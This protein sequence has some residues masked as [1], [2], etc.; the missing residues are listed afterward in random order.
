[1]SP[2]ECRQST[3]ELR[4]VD[5]Q[6]RTVDIVASTFDIDSYG[7]RIDQNG[8]DLAR[9]L[10]NPVICL[11]HDDHGYTGSN[12]LPVA[13][14]IPET[15]RVENNKLV[16]RI[17]FPAEGTFDVADTVFSLVSQG[18]L[19]GVSVGFDP[20][21]DEVVEE[22]DGGYKQS[23]RIY[24]KQELLE[25]SLVTIPS[26][27]KTLVQRARKQKVDAN[28][29]RT[30]TEHMEEVLDKQKV[31]IDPAEHDK[32]KAYFEQKQPANR[33]AT[34]VLAKFFKRV[35]KEEPPA[36]EVEAWKRFAEEV[37][38]MEVKPVEVVVD[39]EKVEEE[40]PAEVVESAP[41]EVKVDE[42]KEE[43]QPEAAVEEPEPAKP[44][45][46]EPEAPAPERKASV[47][48]PISDLLSLQA[49]LTSSYSEAAMEALS[50]GIPA[51]DVLG[52][53]DG[54]NSA[55]STSLSQ[56]PNGNS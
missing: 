36:D 6:A 11:Q 20:H 1:M 29:I 23:V 42:V 22:S 54:M 33:E 40:K 45:V 32:L 47:H 18:F 44:T 34:K 27:D 24:R 8:W 28:V 41:E 46:S 25:V 53:I 2:K 21:E 52:M 7:T 19:R 17:R 13:N 39:E 56:L 37:E 12:G 43:V 16:M 50:R 55:V 35:L 4:A 14:A 10:A 30:M 38:V 48:I 31:E 51:K 9:F 5:A 49:R 15:V 3:A 26:N